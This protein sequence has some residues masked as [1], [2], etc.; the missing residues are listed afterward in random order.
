MFRQHG[1]EVTE[2]EHAIFTRH[3]NDLACI[4]HCGVLELLARG[5]HHTITT[6]NQRRISVHVP[7]LA[8]HTRVPLEG[9]PYKEQDALGHRVSRK[10]DL[11]VY[12]FFSWPDVLAQAKAWGRTI[13]MVAMLWLFLSNP[14]L[15]IMLFGMLQFLRAR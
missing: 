1:F 7:A 11:V 15:C 13:G 4:C 8:L 12:L 5:S 10:G 3:G 9:M 2:K 6:L 14:T